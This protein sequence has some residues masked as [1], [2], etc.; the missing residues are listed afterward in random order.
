M[1]EIVGIG[2]AVLVAGLG[3]LVLHWLP[4]RLLLGGELPRPPA[5]VLGTLAIALPLTGLFF[6]WGLWAAAVA[7]WS[8]VIG[9]GVAVLGAYLLDGW[10]ENRL[11]RAE[12]EVRE[13]AV[14]DVVVGDDT[15]DKS[16]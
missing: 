15:D 12:A 6:A 1:D 5:Y 9:A 10:L 11:G 2:V 16:R 4:W 14:L 7:L 13:R 8:V 3:E